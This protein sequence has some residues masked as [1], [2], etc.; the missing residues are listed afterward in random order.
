MGKETVYIV[1]AVDTEGPL[2]ESLEA[3]FERLEA[4]TGRSL[5]RG[6]EIIQQIRRKELDLGGHE[7][8]AAKMVS[9]E[10]IQ[11]NDNWEKIDQM[12]ARIMAPEFRHR[13]LDS[14]GNG[15]VYNWFSRRN[16]STA[17][18]RTITSITLRI[19]LLAGTAALSRTLFRRPCPTLLFSGAWKR[20]IRARRI[21]TRT[22]SMPISNERRL[23]WILRPLHA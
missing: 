20:D 18:S 3:T 15:W 5:S 12:L 19:R 14:N 13:M 9:P 22:P 4:I 6:A 16:V 21:S 1:H 23:K 7:D 17:C 11:Y 2:H 8:A 10:L